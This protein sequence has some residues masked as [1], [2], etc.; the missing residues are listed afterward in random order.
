ML[1][2]DGELGGSARWAAGVTVLPTEAAPDPA[3]LAELAEA[4][5]HLT[6]LGVRW[7]PARQPAPEGFVAVEP[8]GTGAAVVA[9]LLQ[10]AKER[11]AVLSTGCRVTGLASSRTGW[12][13][14]TDACGTVDGRAVVVATGGTLGSPEAASAWLGVP[15]SLRLGPAL[16]DGSGIALARSV[17]ATTFDDGRA[18]WFSHV[19]P[20]P[21]RAGVGRSVM[22]SGSAVAVDADG[23]VVSGGLRGRGHTE[24]SKAPT[25]AL[26]SAVPAASARVFDI[27][28]G[29]PVPLREHLGAGG[30]VQSVSVQGLAEGTGLHADALDVAFRPWQNGAHGALPPGP[31]AAVPLVVTPSKQLGGLLTDSAGGVLDHAQQEIPGLFAAGEASGFHGLH[32]DRLPVDSTMVVGAVLTGSRAGEA[33]ATSSR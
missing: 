16:T 28:T 17:G 4:V 5:D 11:G 21:S 12:T 6:D 29:R 7:Q 20:H 31:Y 15:V 8:V 3:R 13:V 33:A 30:G 32:R 10:A 23:A 25:W 27:E 9:A 24:P 18:L 1:E 26:F 19:T 14:H 22:A 2:A